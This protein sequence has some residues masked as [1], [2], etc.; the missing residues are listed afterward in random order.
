MK[1]LVYFSIIHFTFAFQDFFIE[2]LGWFC[3]NHDKKYLSILF[4]SQWT[5]S[6]KKLSKL[7]NMDLR[8]RTI[9]NIVDLEDQ[10]FFVMFHSTEN[11]FQDW[12]I[13]SHR[14]IKSALVVVEQHQLDELISIISQENLS[15]NLY[16]LV[17]NEDLFEFKEI[18]K[19]KNQKSVIVKSAYKNEIDLQG[20]H[21]PTITAEW[22]PY[23][24]IDKCNQI[25]TNCAIKGF[26]VDIMD[27]AADYMNFTWN[28]EIS[29][30]WGMTPKSGPF[31]MSGEWGGVMGNIVVGNYEISV[32]VW[33]LNLERV[34]VMDHAIVLKDDPSILLT[35]TVPTKLDWSFYK[36]PFHNKLWIGIIIFIFI[37]AM[38]YWTTYMFSSNALDITGFSIWIFF[39]LIQAFYCGALTMFFISQVEAPFKNLD[40]AILN[41]PNWNIVFTSGWESMFESQAN[42]VYPLFHGFNSILLY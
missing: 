27:G 22:K 19:L 7:M 10:D 42:K 2:K 4:P 38:I 30:D 41:F 40:E 6:H 11:D 26:A 36:R 14:L 8:V 28:A 9:E 18:L 1:I 21:I 32:N 39:T 24:K 37:L 25:G 31:N 3:S 35:K 33:L 23:V 17:H 34:K 12:N 15:L 5:Y 13:V 20:I 16:C 29:N